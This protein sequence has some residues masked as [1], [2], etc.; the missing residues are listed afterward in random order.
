MKK[1]TVCPRQPFLMAVVVDIVFIA[2][3]LNVVVIV[4]FI[5]V[6]VFTVVFVIVSGADSAVLARRS[7]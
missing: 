3:V 1:T 5:L 6:I 4:V 7:W 2:V